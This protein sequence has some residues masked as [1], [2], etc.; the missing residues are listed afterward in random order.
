MHLDKRR[1]EERKG[2]KRDLPA[3]AKMD[4]ASHLSKDGFDTCLD[5][6]IPLLGQLSL[7]PLSLSLA[8]ESIAF[9]FHSNFK[10]LGK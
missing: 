3:S 5:K 10:S 6:R 1:G 7:N 8:Y 9:I 2:F 4:A